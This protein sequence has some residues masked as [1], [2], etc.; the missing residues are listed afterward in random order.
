MMLAGADPDFLGA[1]AA[2]VRRR[3][4]SWVEHLAV[5]SPPLQLGRAFKHA[6]TTVFRFEQRLQ[7]HHVLDLELMRLRKG[8]NELAG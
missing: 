4:T 5:P 2:A 7:Q 8:R 6:L 1:S 3:M